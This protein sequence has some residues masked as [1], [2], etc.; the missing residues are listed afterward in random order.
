MSFSIIT[1]VLNGEQY[2]T[3]CI[4][5]VQKQKYFNDKE[6]IIIDGGSSDRTLSIIKKFQKDYS[7][8]ICLVNKNIGIY[9][10]INIG[11][12]L[13][14]NDIVG[15][16]NSDDFYKD[17]KI[18]KNLNLIESRCIGNSFKC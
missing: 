12:K 5:S 11:L 13:A 10:G 15:I 18:F 1:T 14:K 4:E 17:T 16:L 6:H 3:D 2:I 8:I 9:E 7:N